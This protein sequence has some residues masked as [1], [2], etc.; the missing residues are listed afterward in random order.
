MSDRV[1]LVDSL[2][3]DWDGKAFVRVGPNK[4]Q[5]KVDPTP[6]Y[7]HDV[8]LACEILDVC[9]KAL[10]VPIPPTVYVLGFDDLG[11]TNGQTSY[12]CDY[13]KK[14]E[15]GRGQRLHFIKLYGKRI[16]PHPA[17]TRYLVA[18]EYGHVVEDVI[19]FRLFKSESADQELL[20]EYAKIRGLERPSYYGPGTWHATP[21]EVFANDFRILVAGVEKEFWPHPGIQRPEECFAARGWWDAQLEAFARRAA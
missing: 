20:T 2:E 4:W 8:K 16:P 7:A 1:Q 19:A 9:E 10:P 21:G 5:H 18:H 17:V 13:D 15:H 12:D 3:W 14:D 11:R 6:G